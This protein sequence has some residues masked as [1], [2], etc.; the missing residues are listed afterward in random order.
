MNPEYQKELMEKYDLKI[1][2]IV[3]LI[4]KE[5]AKNVLLQ[6]PDGLKPVAT[7]VAERIMKKLKLPA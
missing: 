3:K 4:R 2:K 6:F 5:K 7:L 1:E